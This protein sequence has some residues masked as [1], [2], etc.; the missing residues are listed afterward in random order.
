[1]SYFGFLLRFLL[2]PL[3]LLAMLNLWDGWRGRKLPSEM[4]GQPAWVVVLAHV[5]VAVVYTTPWDNYLVATR[6]WWY[7]PARVIGLTFGWVPVE[8]YMF[9]ILQTIMT[10]L[11]FIWLARRLTPRGPVPSRPMVRRYAV[12]S[13]VIL[14]LGFASIFVVNWA[15]GTYLALEFTWAL[16]PIMLQLGFGADIL[17]RYRRLIVPAILVPT[18]YLSVAD[19][20]AIGFGTWTFS[21]VKSTG[22]TVAGILPVEELLF[23][24][25]T[26]TLI[27]FGMALVMSSESQPRFW[28]MVRTVRRFLIKANHPGPRSQQRQQLGG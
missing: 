20:T 24:L 2:P 5:V 19:S 3:C 28:G 13:A 4:R 23:F 1:V 18:L 7:D 9:F 22:W 21:P 25:L 6:V 16:L 10:G 8:E 26:N 14:W 12:A 27:C 15:P 11:W 17:W